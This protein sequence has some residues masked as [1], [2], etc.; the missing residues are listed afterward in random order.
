MCVDPGRMFCTY[1]IPYPAQGHSIGYTLSV[2]DRSV[3][4]QQLANIHNS[5]VGE[6][7]GSAGRAVDWR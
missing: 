1:F 6:H 4:A 5:Q 7:S 2:G 3:T